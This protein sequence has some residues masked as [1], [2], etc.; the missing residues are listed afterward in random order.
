MHLNT[1]M[2][3]NIPILKKKFINLFTLCYIHSFTAV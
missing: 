1:Q 2:N 3:D